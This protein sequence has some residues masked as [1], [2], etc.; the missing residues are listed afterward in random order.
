[1]TIQKRSKK[2]NIQNPGA[3]P[4]E[5]VKKKIYGGAPGKGQKENIW[6]SQAGAAPPE[7]GQK[8]K[9]FKIQ[10]RSPKGRVV[11]E[12]TVPY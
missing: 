11:G 5:K 6:R 12:P 9:I 10:G 2:E 4:P 1:L 3:E 7:K 8:K